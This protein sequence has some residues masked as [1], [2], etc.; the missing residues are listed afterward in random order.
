MKKKTKDRVDVKKTIKVVS[1]Y[2]S[3]DFNKSFMYTLGMD[4]FGCHN[5]LIRDIPTFLTP[6]AMGWLN[7][8]CDYSLNDAKKPILPGQNMEISP[9]GFVVKFEPVNELE[10][11]TEFHCLDDTLEVVT[12]KPVCQSCEEGGRHEHKH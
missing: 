9:L 2:D 7:H 12:V 3:E 11:K 8:L 1:V 6:E 5:F 4:N 10:Q